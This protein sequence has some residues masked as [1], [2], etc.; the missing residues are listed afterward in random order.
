MLRELFIDRVVQIDGIDGGRSFGELRVHLVLVR[1]HLLQQ[2]LHALQRIPVQ[3]WSVTRELAFTHFAL[4]NQTQHFDD[5]ALAAEGPKCQQEKK[6]SNGQAG[7]H[8]LSE[9]RTCT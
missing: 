6:N 1:V 2:R 3:S 4:K 9:A 5:G 8:V 7:S